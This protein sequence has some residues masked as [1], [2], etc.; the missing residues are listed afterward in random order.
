MKLQVAFDVGS[1]SDLIMLLEKV[2][3]L[4]D[5]VEIGTPLIVKEGVKEIENIKNRFPKK[6]ILADM[7]IMDAGELEAKIGFDVGA[8]IVTC[9]GL[10][11]SKTLTGAQKVASRNNGK[12]MV[13]MINHNNSIGKWPEFL[14]MGIDYCCLHTAHD[15]AVTGD[16]SIE[17]LE[18]FYKTHGGNNLAVAGGVNPDLIQ[19]MKLFQP[20]I[21]VVGSYITDSNEPREA[22]E[23]VRRVM[24]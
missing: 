18:Q 14:E 20:E 21:V 6:T 2:E 3:D 17:I 22:V 8:D 10:A 5:I 9:L 11:S 19:D 12:I 24:K 7:K 13:D 4:I 15:D 16:N 1:F 23:N